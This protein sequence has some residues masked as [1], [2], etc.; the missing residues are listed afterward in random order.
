[1][2]SD[3]RETNVN[4]GR[5]R[6]ATCGKQTNNPTYCSRSCAAKH[7][8]RSSPKRSLEGKC[9]DCGAAI[10]SRLQ[11]CKVC[12]TKATL[13]ANQAKMRA[14]QNI[15]ALRNLSGEIVELPLPRI[16]L[17]EYFVYDASAY[18]HDRLTSD[19]PCKLLLDRLLALVFAKPGYLRSADIHRHATLI[20]AFGQHELSQGWDS[21]SRRVA[22]TELPIDRVDVALRDWIESLLRHDGWSLMPTFALETG[23]LIEAHVRGHTASSWQ[24]QPWQIKPIIPGIDDIPFSRLADARLKKEITSAFAG[25]LVRFCVPTGCRIKEPATGTV[26]TEPGIAYLGVERCHLSSGIY[27]DTD[28]ELEEDNSP[29]HDIGEEFMMRGK[30]WPANAI[31]VLLDR[32][33]DYD[34]NERNLPR[35]EIPGRWINAWLATNLEWRDVPAWDPAA[36]GG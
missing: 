26:T 10:S 13:A 14:E 8:N 18:S 9:L 24:G 23:R 33:R 12:Q 20:H 21:S 17:N 27:D 16:H 19:K 2:H 36:G 31:E 11:R 25:I 28:L 35:T 34:F 3:G 32:N 22:V 6:C 7:T 15:H 4:I 30:L 29:A 5:N 1:M